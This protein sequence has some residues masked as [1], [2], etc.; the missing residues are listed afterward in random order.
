[1]RFADPSTSGEGRSKEPGLLARLGRLRRRRRLR[2]DRGDW[3]QHNAHSV[4]HHLRASLDGADSEE[5]GLYLHKYRFAEV[6]VLILAAMEHHGHTHFILLFEELFDVLRLGFKVVFGYSGI[7][8][9]LFQHARFLFLAVLPRL[10]V[11]LV[12]ILGEIHYFTDRRIRHR[13]DLYQ[14]YIVFPSQP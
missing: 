3:R 9:Y 7:E 4:A 11:K 13:G 6:P 5:R 12:E 14:I 8:A 10:L 1:M 2:R